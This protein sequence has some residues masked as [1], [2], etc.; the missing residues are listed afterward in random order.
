MRVVPVPVL[1]DNYA[2]VVVDE[3]TNEAA[4]VDPSEATPLAR[5]I[6]R[7]GVNVSS[8]LCTHHHLD[9]VGGN[10]G[11]VREFGSLRVYGHRRDKDRTPCITD[12]VDE[13]DKITVGALSATVLFIPCH[14]S[15][16][17]AY[18]FEKEKTVFTGDTLFVAGCGRLF[19]GTAADMHRNMVKLTALPAETRIYCGHEYT[20]GNL[21]FALTLEPENAKVRAKLDWTRKM[22]AK[23]LPTIPSTVAEEKET[24]PFVRV[25]SRE[26]Q[27]T[28]KK[29]FPDL[30]LDPVSVLE[31]A[32]ALKDSF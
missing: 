29:R 5:V 21:R 30:A 24:N 10:E 31:R 25:D 28:L 26:L 17:V 12:L 14:T 7:E 23:N 20:E 18:H 9:H 32:R 3:S 11:L 6:R 4:V 19:E 2:Y 16:H 15:G 8:I 22:R 1:A 27:Q 13:G